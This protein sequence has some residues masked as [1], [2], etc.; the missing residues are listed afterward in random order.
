MSSEDPSASIGSEE[1]NRI[2]SLGDAYF[3]EH[4]KYPSLARIGNGVATRALPQGV[5][6][7]VTP[8]FSIELDSN[9]D[10]EEIVFGP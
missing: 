3:I 7:A 9:L 2:I 4:G 1:I 6:V 5:G 10:P 8:Y